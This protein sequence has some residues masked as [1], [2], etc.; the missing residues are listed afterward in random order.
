[1]TLRIELQKQVLIVTAVAMSTLDSF[2]QFK[3]SS[4]SCFE[5]SYDEEFVFG[6]SL[7]Q[8]VM[9]VVVEGL[10]YSSFSLQHL[11][12]H[13]EDIG[14]LLVLDWKSLGHEVIRMIN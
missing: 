7:Q 12:V 13:S 5:V 9:Q 1:M 10:L 6:V 2:L 4:R 14:K 3:V 11:C 8:E